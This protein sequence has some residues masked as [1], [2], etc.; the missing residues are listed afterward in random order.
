MGQGIRTFL[1]DEHD[2]LTS[3]SVARFERLT[4]FGSN[5]RIERFA[6]QRLRWVL[7]FVE[8]AN[9]RPVAIERIECGFFKF[10]SDGL[11]DL[12]DFMRPMR[13]FVDSMLPQDSPDRKVRDARARFARKRSQHEYEWQLTPR[14][15][16]TIS[17]AIFPRRQWPPN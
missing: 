13:W 15:E 12:E 14:L 2:Q 8:T 11:L 17:E 5:E 4:S 16:R 10:R 6:G 7:V 9:R 3:I 1:I